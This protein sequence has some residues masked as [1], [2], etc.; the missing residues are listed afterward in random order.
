MLNGLMWTL[1]R[2]Y[3]TYLFFQLTFC[4]WQLVQGLFITVNCFLSKSM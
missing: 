4:L 3:V 1:S 2:C